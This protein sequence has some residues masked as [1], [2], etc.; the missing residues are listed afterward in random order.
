MINNKIVI[1][2]VFALGITLGWVSNEYTNLESD[3]QPIELI[4]S[5]NEISLN[6]KNIAS[7]PN[8]YVDDST[9]N[10]TFSN[11]NAKT[12]NTLIDNQIQSGLIPEKVITADKTISIFDENKKTSINLIEFDEA[13]VDET[14]SFNLKEN[15]SQV[16]VRNIKEQYKNTDDAALKERLFEQILNYIHSEEN[17]GFANELL[18]SQN[19]Q[20][21][22]KGY[23]LFASIRQSPE[24]SQEIISSVWQESEASVAVSAIN[25]LNSA[26]VNPSE[27]ADYISSLTD[28]WE[29]HAN[30]DVRISALEKLSHIDRSNRLDKKL[31]DAIINSG[32]QKA[33]EAAIIVTINSGKQSS[34]IKNVLFDYLADKDPENYDQYMVGVVMSSLEN[35]DINS[36]EY[37]VLQEVKRNLLSIK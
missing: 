27:R 6:K 9:G 5:S 33:K 1:S 25:S 3:Y 8:S 12:L 36:V 22:A 19:S 7:I 34:K 16:E 4:E 13:I 11:D 17:R 37:D 30:D 26:T 15:L 29:N 31:V 14:I 20:E 23:A 35:F 10:V 32:S 21:R 28:V 24:K 2:A 18:N